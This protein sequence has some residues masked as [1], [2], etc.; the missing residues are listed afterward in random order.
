MCNPRH[1]HRHRGFG[2]GFPERPFEHTGD[3][4]V[5]VNILK[6]DSGYELRV[7]APDRSKKDFK[8]TLKGHE[9]TISY[10]VKNQ[11][12]ESKWLRYE[13][14]KSSFERTFLIDET[15]DREKIN[16][17]YV[18]GIL[19]INLLIVPGTEQPETA[20]HIQ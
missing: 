3:Y 6:T 7:F 16:A 9:L 1:H 14:K 12:R 10:E 13:F 2:A 19:Q 18:N 8:I 5:P 4:R 17:E 15:I 11:G 20:I